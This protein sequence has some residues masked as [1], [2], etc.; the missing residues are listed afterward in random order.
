MVYTAFYDW[1]VKKLG[2]VCDIFTSGNQTGRRVEVLKKI[3]L[4]KYY[5]HNKF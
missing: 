3:F 1:Q 4:K 5:E 2:E